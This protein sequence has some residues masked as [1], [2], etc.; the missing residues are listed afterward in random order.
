MPR[1]EA[2]RLMNVSARAH[3]DAHDF[4]DIALL[5]EAARIVGDLAAHAGVRFAELG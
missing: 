1:Q 3:A 5:R 2:I 4:V